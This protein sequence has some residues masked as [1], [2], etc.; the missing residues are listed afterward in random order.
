[1]QRFLDELPNGS[2]E[3]KFSI[4]IPCYSEGHTEAGRAEGEGVFSVVV[5]DAGPK[6]LASALE[7]YGRR[8]A[9]EDFW[10]ARASEEAL[11]LAS[12]P[13]AV[14]YLR[15][16][17]RSGRSDC[18]VEALGKFRGDGDALN[19]L[20][21][22]VRG[23]TIIPRVE[24]AL[25]VLRLWHYGLSEPDFEDLIARANPELTVAALR[26][27]EKI[28]GRAYLPAITA[29]VGGADRGVANEALRARNSILNGDH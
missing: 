7:E 15:T 29:L 2:S 17:A 19:A 5:L 9:S 11:C 6:N 10:E 25:D 3:V 4:D 20:L 14:P 12:T 8:L 26:Y 22:T 23:N 1:L 27:A 16:L 24:M 21:E 13:A 28:N 18:A